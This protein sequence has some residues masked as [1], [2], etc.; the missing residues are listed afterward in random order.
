MSSSSD[1]E[2]YLGQETETSAYPP[3]LVSNWIAV[4]RIKIQKEG[5]ESAHSQESSSI[6]LRRQSVLRG[7]ELFLALAGQTS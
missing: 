6:G 1:T 7:I 3:W 2:M 5:V 4:L